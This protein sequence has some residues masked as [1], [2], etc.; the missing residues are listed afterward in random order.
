[1]GAVRQSD[2]PLW[3]GEMLGLPKGVGGCAPWSITQ[4]L[5]PPCP[6]TALQVLRLLSPSSIGWLQLGRRFFAMLRCAGVL[7]ERDG[8][9]GSAFPHQPLPWFAWATDGT[10]LGFCS[11][12]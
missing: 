3:K 1:M 9:R 8:A 2:G 6:D 7:E 11:W 10:A 12:K 4:N 5:Q